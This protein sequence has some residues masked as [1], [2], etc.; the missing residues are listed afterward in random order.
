VPSVLNCI[1][2]LCHGSGCTEHYT[3]RYHSE[4]CGRT[5][6]TCLDNQLHH[7]QLTDAERVSKGLEPLYAV[8]R[9]TQAGVHSL[10]FNMSSSSSS[11][12]VQ[13]AFPVPQIS[14]SIMTLEVEADSL[15]FIQ[16]AAPGEVRRE[17]WASPLFCAV[18]RA[19]AMGAPMGMQT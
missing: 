8:S 4:K 9:Y 7:L 1:D 19:R 10:K 12:R 18:I 14:T 17:P 16:N 15:K 11:Q 5:V 6:G 3:C 2:C 13:L